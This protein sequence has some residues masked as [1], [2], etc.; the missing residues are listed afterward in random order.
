MKNTGALSLATLV[1]PMGIFQTR[2]RT[3]RQH[4]HET[5]FKTPPESARPH[6][7][8]H[9]MNGNVTKEG[10]TL[11]LEAM[12][13]IGLGGFQNFDAGTGI[14]K[15]PVEYL[16]PQWLDLKKHAIRE[17]SRLGLE[18]TIHNC[19]GW[20]SSGGPW[21]TPELAMQ[22][23]TWSEIVIDGGS[24][25]SLRLPQPL[26][27]LGFYNDIK[28]IACKSL[29]G[30]H[31]IS[32]SFK[33]ILVNNTELR[34]IGPDFG[35]I[36]VQPASDSKTG[37]LQIDFLEPQ[38]IQQVSFV[39]SV[40]GNQGGPII[41][42]SSSDGINYTDVMTFQTGFVFD[43][44]KLFVENI[45]SILCSSVRFICSHDS[46]FSRVLFSN[47]PR[48]EEWKKRANY[49]FN[50]HGTG[51]IT[52]LP[53]IAESDIIDVSEFMKTDGTLEWNAPAGN[54]TI[55]R[56]GFTPIG[57]QNR[58]APDSGV[59][60]EC[61]KYNATAIEFHF[62][63]MMEHLLPSLTELGAK[64]KVGLLID[65]YEVGMQ[66]WTDG[67]EKIF[68]ERNTYD[69]T[70]FL[71]AITGKVVQDADITER[72]LWDFRRTQGDLMA[73]NYYQKFTTL[74][75]KNEIIS[76]CQPYD[77]GP[78]EEMQIGSCVDINV[79][80]FWNGLS[81]IFQNNWTMRRTVKLSASIAHTNGQKIVA[82][83]SYTGEPES[84]KWQEYPF[85][86]KALG[87]RMFTQG[88]NRMVFHR[89]AHQPHPTARPGMTMG[90]WGSHFDR[91]NTWWEQGSAW[92]EY[93]TRCQYMLQ[94]GTFVADIAYY[95]GED[96]GVYTGVETNELKPAPPEGYDYDLINSESLL[97]RA[98]VT[99]G[100]L[101]LSDGIS[102][103][104]LVLQDFDK[105]SLSVIR[106]IDQFVNE[107]LVVV[108]LKPK[109]T[110]DLKSKNEPE[111]KEISDR[112]WGTD[113]NNE[114]HRKVGKGRVIW[115]KSLQVIL[116][117][118]KIDKDFSFTSQS[119]DA[120]ITYI[121][122]RTNTEDIYFV[123]NQRRTTEELVAA[124]RVSNKGPE[125][126][127]P[128]TGQI[129]S[130]NTF[131][132]K[133]GI[134][135]VPL[136]LAENGSAFIVFRK[137]VNQPKIVEV[138]KDSLTVLSSN[139]FK[140]ER[141]LYPSVKDNFTISLWVKPENHI[142]L[143]TNNFM[144]GQRPWTDYFA[145]YP[146]P[147]EKLYGTNHATCGLAAGR[148][149]IAVWEHA[150]EK[151]EFIFSVKKSLSGW[152]HVALTYTQGKPFVHVNGELIHEGPKSKFIIHPGVGH[153]FLNEGASFY[154]G[155]I[156]N[157]TLSEKALDA[158]ELKALSDAQPMASSL[159]SYV[160]DTGNELVF[161]EQGNYEINYPSGKSTL[162]K[163]GKLE[164]LDLSSS[165]EVS[166]PEASGAP[167]TA[168]LGRLIPLNESEDPGVKYFSGTCTYSRT[169]DLNPR[170]DSNSKYYLDLGGVEVLA[171]I[172]LNGKSLGVIWARPFIV[173]I[174]NTLTTGK[175]LLEIKVTNLWPN[176]LIGDEQEADP[177]KY[178][179]GAGG[180]GFASLSGGAILELPTWYQKGETKP[181]DGRVAFATWKHYHKQSP[182]LA[183]GLIG[184]VVIR[185]AQSQRI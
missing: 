173:D 56:F 91:T 41:L 26:Q 150:K 67:F 127:D 119:G 162:Q 76:Y 171:E 93:L 40:K 160:I 132:M 44:G 138:K 48:A 22:E 88:L 107:G 104:V 64:G 58:S 79:G 156:R 172:K 24:R 18:F 54:W 66:N 27:R 128:V 45:P 155:D 159:Q 16:S 77:R 12:A 97:K 38:S 95:T 50:R 147:G 92:I 53:A 168:K 122:R 17:A 14:P 65:S 23:I 85:G 105:M 2:A 125:R 116:D 73:E 180:S 167:A 35:A 46:E 55:M 81:S 170:N 30:E 126:W 57:T 114:V 115:G 110:P 157:L 179:P 161:F 146:S 87:D 90:P 9:W 148:N 182:L 6:T 99:N 62:Q 175:N 103:R 1:T 34:W 32:K 51:E 13:R 135:R 78:M 174:T 130:I 158:A 136:V 163:I 96:A 149:G 52:N 61:D 142:M 185:S 177:Y 20:S 36:T 42:Q 28:V 152:S 8:W 10:I 165:W 117:D 151:P 80:E 178:A 121:H 5:N 129:K 111:F 141:K 164:T 31:P 15:G 176:R 123:A 144:D 184:P 39:A 134:T 120:P 75:H 133:E 59:G 181:N 43:T 63:K 169:F 145:I 154:N 153:V 69:L 100:R 29:E 166:F 118:L 71:P 86:L 37:F 98:E 4:T 94:Q 102:Y 60:L 83:E 143:A 33:K 70:K 139:P 113:H 72:F 7:W 21:I 11:D 84:S 108:G 124:F 3:G 89:F 25:M 82:A 47:V 131:S 112:L 109:R 19:P 140:V 68:R 183:S 137:D 49:S 106:T 74:C 101:T